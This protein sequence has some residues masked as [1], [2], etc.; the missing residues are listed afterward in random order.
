VDDGTAQTA[1]FAPVAPPAIV[2][3]SYAPA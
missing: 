2:G 3:L 1:R